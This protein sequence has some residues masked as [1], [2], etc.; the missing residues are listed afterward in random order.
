MQKM[1]KA[2][3][4][5]L[6]IMRHNQYGAISQKRSDDRCRF[7][8]MTVIKAARRFVK[9]EDFFAGKQRGRDGDSLL[10][11]AGQGHRVAVRIRQ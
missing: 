6:G 5:Q 1:C 7:F 9:H 8:H 2:A 10:L 4:N 3:E 11:T